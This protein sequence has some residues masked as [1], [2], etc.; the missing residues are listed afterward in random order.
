MTKKI[1][2]KKVDNKKNDVKT[3]TILPVKGLLGLL[4]DIAVVS[5]LIVT[6]VSLLLLCLQLA[7]KVTITGGK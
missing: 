3:L 6:S 5:T 4:A 7:Q 1:A 2:K